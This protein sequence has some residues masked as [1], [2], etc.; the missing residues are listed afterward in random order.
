MVKAYRRFKGDL[1]K[2]FREVMLCNVLDDEDR[3]R[4]IIDEEIRTGHVEGYDAY[5]NEPKQ[6]KQAR[7]KRAEKDAREAEK[8]AEDLGLNGHKKVSKKGGQGRDDDLAAMIQQR[9]AGRAANFLDDLEA[10]YAPRKAKK[11]KKRPSEEPPEEAFH[12]MGSRSKKQKKPVIEEEVGEDEIDLDTENFKD[13]NEEDDD[14]KE[15]EEEFEIAASKGRK[16]KVPQVT[17]SKGRVPR[18]KG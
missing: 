15:E 4:D 17:K 12:K 5:V 10:K 2:L 14:E 8:H 11:G 9:Q 3:F 16:K 6:K 13:G 7:R 1:N 18:K